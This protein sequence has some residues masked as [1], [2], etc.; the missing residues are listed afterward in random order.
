MCTGTISEKDEDVIKKTKE[1]NQKQKSKNSTYLELGPSTNP[2]VFIN[3]ISS[4]SSRTIEFRRD[5]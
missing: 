1:P 4:V 5:R 2:G 3:S